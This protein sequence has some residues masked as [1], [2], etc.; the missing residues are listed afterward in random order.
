M[1]GCIYSRGT[2]VPLI[3]ILIRFL[4]CY[5]SE[6]NIV[7][8]IHFY[9]T[10]SS[11]FE[12]EYVVTNTRKITQYEAQVSICSTLSQINTQLQLDSFWLL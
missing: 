4:L 1:S 2:G 12:D 11:Y 10:V 7:F 6:E 9:F 3:Y 5:I 8:V